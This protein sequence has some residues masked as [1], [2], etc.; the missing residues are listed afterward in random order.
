MMLA[1]EWPR[2]APNSRRRIEEMLHTGC[3]TCRGQREYDRERG[4]VED[5]TAGE[6]A[7]LVRFPGSDQ[8]R[9][10]C[11]TCGWSFGSAFPHADH[12]DWRI[13]PLRDDA[14]IE[15]REAEYKR[16]RE[17]VRAAAAADRDQWRTLYDAFLQTPE[18][19]ALREKVMMCAGRLCESCLSAPAE[20]VH[21]TTYDFGPLAPAYTLRAVCRGFTESFSRARRSRTSPE[22][23]SAPV[24]RKHADSLRF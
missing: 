24:A 11:Q 1:H 14:I 4:A 13:Y 8:I 12:P 19:R 18:W 16:T 23:L 17:A 10:Q 2:M 3:N 21:H 22:T 20:D 7:K 6:F 9:L 5:M 15:A